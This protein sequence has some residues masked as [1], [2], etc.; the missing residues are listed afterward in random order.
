MKVKVK[1]EEMIHELDSLRLVLIL[2]YVTANFLEEKGDM[3]GT[4]F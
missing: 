2:G 4:G 1:E 3:W